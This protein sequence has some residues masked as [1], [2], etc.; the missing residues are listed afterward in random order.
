MEKLMIK[1]VIA[2][3]RGKM[4]TAT[5]QMVLDDSHF[6]LVGVVSVNSTV[7]NMNEL[8]EYS[9][10]DVPIFQTKEEV[11]KALIPD[12]GLILQRQNLF[13]KLFYF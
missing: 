1:I 13:M 6:E 10:I 12:V 2:G 11:I 9:E 7:T 8:K 5:T 4:G 3:F